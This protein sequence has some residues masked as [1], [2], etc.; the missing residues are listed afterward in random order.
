MLLIINYEISMKKNV[1]KAQLILLILSVITPS[2]AISQNLT[3]TVRGKIADIDNK[4]P[5]IGATVIILG[6]EP[7]KGTTSD[8]NG[9]FRLVNIP[10]GRITLQVS[11]LGYE[12]KTIPNIVVNSGKEVVL[13]FSLQESVVKMDEVVVK[14]SKNKGEALNKMSLLSARSVTFEETNRF[15]GAFN[16]PSRMLTN[17]AGVSTQSG[18]NI[19]VR[20]NAPKYVQWRLEGVEIANPSHFDDQNSSSAGMCALNNNLLATSDFYTGAFSPEYG[21]VLSSVYDVKLR[22][23]NNEKFEATFGFGLI[24]TDFTIE[25]PLKKGYAGSYLVNYRY[26]TATIISNLGLVDFGGIPKYQDATF[27]IVLPTKKTGSFSLYGLLGSSSFLFEDIKSD[28]MSTPGNRDMQEN[29]IED[30]EKSNYLLNIGLA[31]TVPINK[32]SYIK[33][34]LSYSAN[35]SNDRVYESRIGRTDNDE[36]VFLYDTTN[37]TLN[38]KSDINTSVIRGAITYNNKLNA[39][40]KIQVGVKYALYNGDQNQS[41]L[42]PDSIRISLVDF[43]GTLDVLRNFIS[44]KYRVNEKIDIVAGIHNMNVLFNRKTTIEPRIAVR[45]AL[46]NSNSIH[47]GYGK[48][49][50]LERLH[51]YYSRV[52]LEDG[53]VVEPNHDLDLLKA[54]HFVLGYKKRFT[55]NLMAKIEAY[56]QDLY[57]L[58]VENIDTS[59]YATINEGVDY[60]YVDLVNKGTGKNYGIEL[61][62][63]KFFANSYYF[64]INTSLFSSQ[65]KS[66][67]DITRNT[68]YNGNYLVNVLGG[69]EFDNL[70]KKYNQILSLNAKVFFG[71]ATKIIPLLR[72]EQGDL[73]VEPQNNKYWDYGRAYDDKIDDIYYITISASYKWNKPKTTH[74]LFFSIENITNA[75][76][77]KSEFYDASEPNS[78]GYKTQTPLFPNFMYRVYF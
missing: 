31:H 71:G 48:H 39:K 54:H 30:F 53:S 50:D 8:T 28:F 78:I 43:N 38:F 6:S 7:L 21:N 26:S 75:Q 77:R 22:A 2:L 76:G 11:C 23:G 58:P 16:D 37:R 12:H 46:N 68:L 47:F 19:I 63:E 35:G 61:T 13:D 29:I 15:A 3:Q 44:W 57:N 5:L 72:N 55:E 9:S 42:N 52:K 36:G 67:E 45:W 33:T 60:R 4:L 62:L 10:A 70:G 49:S 73:A 74:E 14:A 59:Y 24:G 18:N 32:K 41:T 25:G 69:K 56:Y 17:F 66:L 40:N 65:Y 27:K 51:N 34:N 1:Y 20:G 64:L